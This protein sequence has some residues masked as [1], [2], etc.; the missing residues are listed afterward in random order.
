[1]AIVKNQFWDEVG[2][3]YREEIWDYD[4][5]EYRVEEPP[6]NIIEQRALTD[7]EWEDAGLV[8]E[9]AVEDSPWRFQVIERD[10]A[11]PGSLEIGDRILVQPTGTG[12]LAGHDNEIATWDGNAF[13]FEVP[14]EGWVVYSK[15]INEIWAYNGSTWDK[16]Y[17]SDHGDQDGLGDDDHLQYLTAGRH[18]SIGGNPHGLVYSDLSAADP[19]TDVTATELEALTDGSDA[20]AY[21]VHD[22]YLTEAE[23]DGLPSDNPHSVTL[24]QA[25]AADAGTDVTAAEL[26]TLTDGSNADAEHSH[27]PIDGADHNA[28]TNLTTGD[29]HTQYQLRSEKSQNNGYASLGGTGL[30]PTGELGTGTADNSTYLR[31]DGFWAPVA[32]GSALTFVE[33]SNQAMSNVQDTEVL[34]FNT[35]VY[36]NGGIWTIT[37]GGVETSQAGTYRAFAVIHLT[38]M[39][40]T[41]D[42]EV[43]FRI[44]GV[45]Q[46]ETAAAEVGSSDAHSFFVMDIMTLSPGDEVTVYM[47]NNDGDNWD[48][49]VNESVMTLELIS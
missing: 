35:S 27:G 20:D 49:P 4:I 38:G 14:E 15:E 44:N 48:M 22:Q 18:S 16:V 19:G 39:S 31:G 7:D 5:G 42:I 10:T 36:E 30:V 45:N 37:T 47:S 1:M 8:V 3:L 25:V 24:T 21:H 41:T 2:T 28:L 29:P 9:P 40:G 34:W 32:G 43:V 13:T 23:H 11:T 33:L 46:I 26:E 12:P 6:G 17:P